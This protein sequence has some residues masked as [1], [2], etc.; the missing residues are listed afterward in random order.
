MI[1]SFQPFAV[2]G[3]LQP[4]SDQKIFFNFSKNKEIKIRTREF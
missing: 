3:R 4:F 1:L 2:S